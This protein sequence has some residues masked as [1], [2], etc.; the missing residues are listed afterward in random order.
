MQH[1]YVPVRAA[2][3][4]ATFAA[5]LAACGGGGGGS[6][7][8]TPTAPAPSA[9]EKPATRD[10]ATRFLTQASFGP[11]DADVGRVSSVGYAAWI[12]EQLALPA[13]SH[14]ATWEAADAAIKTADATKAAGQDQVFESFWKQ[15]VTGPDQ[16]RQRVAYALSQIFVISLV[17]STVGDNPDRKSVV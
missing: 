17:D 10:D 8:T 4:A 11:V 9:V 12:D 14:R 5:L 1:S 13:T 16:L 2:L 3:A 6:D 7:S 15:A